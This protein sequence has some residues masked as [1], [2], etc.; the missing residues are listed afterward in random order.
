MK[1]TFGT[2]RGA[3]PDILKGTTPIQ[4]ELSKVSISRPSGINLWRASFSIRQCM[5]S[6]SCHCIRMAQLRSGRGHFRSLAVGFS[7]TVVIGFSLTI[8]RGG[9]VLRKCPLTQL[10]GTFLTSLL[11]FKSGNSERFLRTP[12]RQFS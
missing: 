1:G 10:R 3:T 6:K 2:Y 5:K 11:I 4:A 8:P 7:N 9:T 12:F